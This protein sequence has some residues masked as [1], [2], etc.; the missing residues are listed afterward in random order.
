[1][2]LARFNEHVKTI[3]TLENSLLSDSHSLYE[4]NRLQ[5]ELIRLKNRNIEEPLYS[6]PV[7]QL[8]ELEVLRASLTDTDLLFSG[9][10]T[11][12]TFGNRVIENIVTPVFDSQ[13]LFT[14]FYKSE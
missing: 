1:M 10:M 14:S 7:V 12:F 2:D 5:R 6:V 8:A 11:I 13:H 3:A 9:H 4:R